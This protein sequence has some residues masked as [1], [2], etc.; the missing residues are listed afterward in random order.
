MLRMESNFENESFDKSEEISILLRI[1]WSFDFTSLQIHQQFSQKQ[2]NEE[3]YMSVCTVLIS[4]ELDS[5]MDFHNLR[6]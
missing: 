4:M 5:P 2:Y 1:S 6:M 3:S